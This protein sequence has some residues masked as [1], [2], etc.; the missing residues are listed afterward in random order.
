MYSQFPEAIGPT[1]RLP[2]IAETTT[3]QSKLAYRLA[4]S[5]IIA[6]GLISLLS[7]SFVAAALVDIILSIGLLQ[8]RAGARRWMIVRIVA[9]AILWPL[10]AF[11]QQS[12]GMAI[13]S[14][15][16][17][18]MLSGSFL[19]LLTGRSSTWR[20]VVASVLFGF[21]MFLALVGLLVQ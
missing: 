21:V 12:A 14:A 16:V 9:G 19:L 4:G 17:M 6:A 15:V 2:A 10:L 3:G 11:T 20:I 13:A 5:F 8:L 1:V 18:W 7:G